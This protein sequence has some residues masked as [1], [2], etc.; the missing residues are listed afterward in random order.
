M[1]K[2]IITLL[3]VLPLG[4]S[5][6]AIFGYLSYDI[7]RRQMPEYAVAEKEIAN[8][9]QKYEQEA[10]RSE[11]EFKRKFSEYLIGQKDFP[12]NIL[13]K[14]QTELQDLM[15]KSIAF[16]EECQE[17]LKKARTDIMKSVDDKIDQA[18]SAASTEANLAFVINTDTKAVPIVNSSLCAD[19]T[20]P[21]LIKLGIVQ[22]E[23]K[24]EP[25]IEEP[26]P[27]PATDTVIEAVTE[28]ETT[29]NE[30]Q[31]SQDAE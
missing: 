14:R 10:Q 30:Q 24:P 18:V 19:L 7:V 20:L 15:E 1:K 27:E 13:L 25:V 8:L 23:P 17:L 22:P 26:T 21:V 29:V 3:L 5:A 11:E 4:A 6:Q 28:V 16:R 9:Q 2:L 31:N 12:E